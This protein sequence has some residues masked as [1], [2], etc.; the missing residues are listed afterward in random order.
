MI[1]YFGQCGPQP[2]SDEPNGAGPPP[3]DG[4]DK[5]I[6]AQSWDTLARRPCPSGAKPQS[7]RVS[8]CAPDRTRRGLNTQPVIPAAWEAKDN[9]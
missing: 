2:G 6:G 9:N 8:V 7:S 3:R 5:G 1:S 4:I